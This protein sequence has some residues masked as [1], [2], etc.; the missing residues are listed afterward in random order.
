MHIQNEIL[1]NHK[2]NHNYENLDALG[3]IMLNNLIHQLVYPTKT[4]N[5]IDSDALGRT[6]DNEEPLVYD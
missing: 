4:S 6:R 3:T 1:F 2:E 5:N